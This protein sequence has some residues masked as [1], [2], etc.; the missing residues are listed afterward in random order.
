MVANEPE[1][2]GRYFD[3]W[4]LKNRPDTMCLSDKS[5]PTKLV[6]P[7]RDTSNDNRSIGSVGNAQWPTADPD[8]PFLMTLRYSLGDRVTRRIRPG[9]TFM[10]LVPNYRNGLGETI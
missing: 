4:K 10:D 9:P 1:K 2:K 3:L 8:S 5:F 6:D 7:I